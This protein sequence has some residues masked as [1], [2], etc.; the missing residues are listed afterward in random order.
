MDLVEYF[1]D[2]TSG[3]GKMRDCG[4]MVRDKEEYLSENGLEVMRNCDGGRGFGWVR[5]SEA[6]K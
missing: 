2:C 6:S 4:L 1:G 5:T 3:V